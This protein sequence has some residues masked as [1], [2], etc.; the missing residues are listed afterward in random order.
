MIKRVINK[1]VNRGLLE[2]MEQTN[3]DSNLGNNTENTEDAIYRMDEDSGENS[4][5]NSTTYATHSSNQFFPSTSF[6][7]QSNSFSQIENLENLHSQIQQVIA[8]Q[9]QLGFKVR[10]KHFKAIG[11]SFTINDFIQYTETN[12]FNSLDKKSKRYINYQLKSMMS[13]DL[14]TRRNQNLDDLKV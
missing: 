4:V 13:E 5:N 3:D 7:L 6:P 8:R 14:K 11:K 10:L 2:D 1:L 9:E 12:Q